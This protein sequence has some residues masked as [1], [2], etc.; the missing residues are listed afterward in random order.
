MLIWYILILVVALVNVRICKN[1]FF[2]DYVGKKQCDAIKGV[3]ILL[4]FLGH[5][6]TFIKRCGFPFDQRIDW[7][8]QTFHKAMGQLVVAL[9]FFYSGFGVM[10]S[11]IDKGKAYLD[12]YPKRRILTTLLNFDMAVCCFILLAF[13]MGEELSLSRIVLSFIGWE[14]YG[15]SNW[16]IFVILCCYL[17]FYVVFKAVGDRFRLGTIILTLVLLLGVFAL[18]RCKPTTWYTT[19]LVFPS[20][21]AYALYSDQ[22]ERWIQKRYG[23]VVFLLVVAFVSLCYLMKTHPLHGLTFNAKAIVFALLIVILTMKIRLGNRWL[24]WCGFSLFPLYIYQRLPMIGLR[25]IAGEEWICGHPHFFI[26]VCFAVSVG[27]ALLYNRF[28]RIQLS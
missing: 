7:C 3:F 27:I 17:A 6:L 24:Y 8:A 4:V 9:F 28:F 13:F 16:Y 1:G 23:L 10:K 19:V 21:V 12:T 25:G 20:G 2:P 26:G 11:L 18:Y 15:N 22:L 14:S 5:I